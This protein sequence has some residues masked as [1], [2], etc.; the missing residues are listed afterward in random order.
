MKTF[1]VEL[2]IF[3]YVMLCHQPSPPKENE[4]TCDRPKYV[5]RFILYGTL[6]LW[7][8]TETCRYDRD[9]F[10][11]MGGTAHSTEMLLSDCTITLNETS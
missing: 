3:L 2:Y 4:F 9:W 6:L 8:S 7:L 1:E 11:R 5:V 10:C